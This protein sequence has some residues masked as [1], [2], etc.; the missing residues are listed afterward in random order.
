VKLPP[1]LLVATHNPGKLAEWRL[2]LEPWGVEL[3]TPKDRG[4]P[5]PEET[6]TSY[7]GNARL[8]AVAAAA[9]TG[10][11]ALADDTGFEADALD[12]APGVLTAPW[13]DAHGGYP[14]ALQRLIEQAGAGTPARLVCAVAL[15]MNDDTVVA[16]ASIEGV[17]RAEPVEAPGFAAVLDSGARPCLV[18]GVLAHRRA[19]FER[20]IS[21]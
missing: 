16:Q 13:A 21:R 5:E 9:H 8:K 11:P 17:V 15:S 18:D 3:V 14:A 7:R 1:Q 10:M 19:A 2:L 6:Q 4:L 20:L 12:G